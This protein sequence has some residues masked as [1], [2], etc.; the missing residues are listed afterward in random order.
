MKVTPFYA[1]EVARFRAYSNIL[2]NCN[3]IL[4][5]LQLTTQR[6]MI[7]LLLFY[8]CVGRDKQYV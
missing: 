1:D 2:C 3:Y 4:G 5:I 6:R 8:F 7:I